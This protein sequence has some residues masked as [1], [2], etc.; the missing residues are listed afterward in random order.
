M[1][2][3]KKNL[4]LPGRAYYRYDEAFKKKVL[5]DIDQGLISE[6]KTSELYQINRKCLRQWRKDL[7][8]QAESG[9]IA[10][11]GVRLQADLGVVKE[12][13]A[14]VQENKQLREQ[15][16][17]EKLRSEALQTIIEVAELDLGISIQK[18]P[19]PQR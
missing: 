2:Y 11:Q 14:L 12:K 3:N 18:K 9:T 19:S 5:S 8:L 1:S 17:H 15:L 6:R 13:Q 16:V 10:R 4:N 7:L